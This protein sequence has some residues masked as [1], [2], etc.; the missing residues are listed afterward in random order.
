MAEGCVGSFVFQTTRP[1]VEFAGASAGVGALVTARGCR[2]VLLVTD[3]GVVRA[4]R[5]EGRAERLQ[6]AGRPQLA[7]NAKHRT[8]LPINKL[9][10]M[11][12]DHAATIYAGAL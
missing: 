11:T 1:G 7:E 2:K 4:G 6:R 3:P 5:T 8:L 10:E 9:W 12:V